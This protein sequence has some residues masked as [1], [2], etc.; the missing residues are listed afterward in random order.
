VPGIAATVPAKVT[1]MS[2]ALDAGSTTVELWLELGNANR[3]LK[4]GTPVHAQIELGAVADAIL[5]PSGAVLH[6]SGDPAYAVF[7][8]DSDGIARRREIGVGMHDANATQVLHGLRSD[9][10]V[11]SEGVILL[12]DGD[13]VKVDP[14]H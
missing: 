10:L 6:P 3:T 12:H 4:P 14:P 1:L 5:V 13:K 7:V 9:D 8:V 11:V 2:P